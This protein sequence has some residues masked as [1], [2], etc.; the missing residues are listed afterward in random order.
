[1]QKEGKGGRGFGSVSFELLLLSCLL[2]HEMTGTYLVLASL[3]EVGMLRSMLQVPRQDQ[4]MFK[5]QHERLS[6]TVSPERAAPFVPTPLLLRSL[7]LS[8]KAK[9][10]S[11]YAYQQTQDSRTVPS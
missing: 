4:K 2:P 3:S 10:D 1:M 6:E 8:E 7:A 11:Q 5:N 9:R